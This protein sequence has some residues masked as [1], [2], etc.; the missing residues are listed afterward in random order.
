[1]RQR[2]LHAQP[3]CART[4]IRGHALSPASSGQSGEPGACGP[5][6]RAAAATWRW[7]LSAPASAPAAAAS[8]APVS[9][10]PRLARLAPSAACADG[11][12][13]LLVAL[14]KG[15]PSYTGHCCKRGG[16]HPCWGHRPSCPPDR[17]AALACAVLMPPNSSSVASSSSSMSAA[18]VSA[19]STSLCAWDAPT[20][21]PTARCYAKSASYSVDTVFATTAVSTWAVQRAV[22]GPARLLFRTCDC[23]CSHLYFLR[24]S[25]KKDV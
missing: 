8:S 19:S 23:I 17:R 10:P 20:C 24:S 4:T 14:F 5:A 9:S 13:L 15:A 3:T 22:G 2:S 12:Y 16:S 1:M 11:P 6:W 7:S 21:T 18:R 25:R